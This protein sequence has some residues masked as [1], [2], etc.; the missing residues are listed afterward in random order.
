MSVRAREEEVEE[1][2]E[3]AAGMQEREGASAPAI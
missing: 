3:E 1:E 2:A